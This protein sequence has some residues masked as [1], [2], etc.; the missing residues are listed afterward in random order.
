MSVP[1]ARKPPYRLMPHAYVCAR[2]DYVVLMDIERGKYLAVDGR[3]SPELSELIEGWP[4]PA[5]DVALIREGARNLEWDSAER[6]VQQLLQRKLLTED[7]G[8]GKTA[9]PVK[10]GLPMEAFPIFALNRS[11]RPYLKFLPNFIMACVRASRLHGN[12]RLARVV[13]HIRARRRRWV[14][15]VSDTET[16]ERL[17]TAHQHLRPL[18]YTCQDQCLYDSMVLLEFLAAYRMDA[19][20]VFGVHTWPWIPHCWVRAGAYLLNDSPGN[21]GRYSILAEF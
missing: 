6:I 17:A 15:R 20:W 10:T 9:A 19:T 12:I 3:R 11:L 1:S 4:S 5:S 14:D 16:L 2:D 13:E 8:I 21:I 18:I 7:P